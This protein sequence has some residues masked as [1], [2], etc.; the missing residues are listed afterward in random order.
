MIQFKRIAAAN[1]PNAAV[2]KIISFFDLD[3]KVKTKDQSGDVKTFVVEDSE[4]MS[5]ALPYKVLAFNITQTG[6]GNPTATVLKNTAKASVTPVFTRSV[7]GFYP[8]ELAGSGAFPDGKIAI[9]TKPYVSSAG[10]VYFYRILRDDDDVFYIETFDSSKTPVE[11]E[12]LNQFIELRI[13][14]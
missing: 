12:F 2:N 3:N 6:T 4:G 7:L 10:D 9:E 8:V 14:P 1:L 13:Y 11:A 5:S